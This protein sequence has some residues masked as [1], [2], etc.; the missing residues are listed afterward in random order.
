[1]NPPD[2]HTSPDLAATR[3]LLQLVHLP[4]EDLHED[5]LASFAGIYDN[6]K[7]VALG[8]LEPYG[9]YALLRSL[10]THPE[11]RGKGLAGYIVS[12]LEEMAR[13]MGV[14]HLYLLTE[15][16]G[17][18]FAGKGYSPASRKEAPSPIASTSQFQ[19]L[20]P[21]SALFMSRQI[22]PAGTQASVE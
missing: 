9:A 15:T 6:G 11:H 10:A 17:P 7:L 21:A 2:I 16:A 22:V 3:S 4:V 18:Y 12:A 1:M 19:G 5:M 20:C 13:S 8:G 14:T